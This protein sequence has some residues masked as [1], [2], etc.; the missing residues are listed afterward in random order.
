M[1][2]L[3]S[4]AI[5]VS[6]TT[7]I[8][9]IA[10]ATGMA[11]SS[12]ASATYTISSGGSSWYNTSWSNRKAITIDHTKMSGSS[13]LTNFPVLISLPSDSNLQS[14]AKPDG[15]DILF[16]ASDGTTKL[17]REIEKYTSSTRPLSAWVQVPTVSPTSAR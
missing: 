6:A 14:P 8:K 2:T 11:D 12:V 1:E 7:T 10:Y 16:T 13:S 17:N 3:Y 15:S 5:T 4:G 9:A